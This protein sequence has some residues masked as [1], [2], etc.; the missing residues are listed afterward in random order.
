[1]IKD[2]PLTNSERVARSRQ[3]NDYIAIR[4][5]KDLGAQIRLAAERAGLPVAQYVTEA[6]LMRMESEK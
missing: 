1:M 6:V 2:R 5:K 4:P 3:N